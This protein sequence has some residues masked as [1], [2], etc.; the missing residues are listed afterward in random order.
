MTNRVL[1]K[2]I[3]SNNAEDNEPETN[4]SRQ[5]D[6]LE[7]SAT[8]ENR[9]RIA[10]SGSSYPQLPSNSPWAPQPDAGF[11]PDRDRI[12][13]NDECSMTFGMD[14][15][16]KSVSPEVCPC[17]PVTS[18]EVAADGLSATSPTFSKEEE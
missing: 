2:N 3:V 6:A 5:Q 9:T 13:P 16:G 8:D 4:F 14:L 15:S 7:A 1:N 12:D 18:G 11:H 10:T 17:P